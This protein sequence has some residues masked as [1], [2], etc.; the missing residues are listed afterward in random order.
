L[1][2]LALVVAL[3]LLACSR[4]QPPAPA[5]ETPAP[6]PR[7]A[8]PPRSGLWVLA[9][10]DERVLEHAEK[11]PR[12]VERAAA[13]G[14]TDLFVQVYRGGRSWFPSD[15]AD[16]AP[17]RRAEQAAGAAPL[18]A[19]T[20]QA[21]A[22]GLRVHAWFNALS[23]AGNRDAPLLRRLGRDAVLVDRRG[24]N[25]LDYPELE[26]PPPDRDWLRVET[27]ALWLDPAT[28]GVVEALEAV[29]DDLV[30]AAPDLDGLH[31]DFIRST[32]T[33][34]ML[35][36]S[37]FSPGLD[38]GY[39][40]PAKA[41]FAAASGQPFARGEA[42]DDWRRERISEVVRRLRARI[43]K[44]W[45]HSAAVLPWADR[46]YLTALQDWRR[47]LEEGSIDFAV[48]M[49]YMRDDR[50]LR[51][52][53]TSLTGGV[54]GDRV[55]IGLGAWL[56]ADAPERIEAQARIARAAGAPGIAF[57]SWD[58]LA[59]RPDA[60]AAIAGGAAPAPGQP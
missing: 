33:L 2:R 29:V 49:A 9:E 25:L 51:Y 21:H 14:V 57:F 11:I 52:V 22:R 8:A 4:E 31:L 12:L 58:S 32:Y 6:A 28:P 35:P 18:S 10:G 23:L 27:P 44:R 15:D 55:W 36:G 53:S 59:T 42:W 45:Q 19:L 34:P 50:L 7:A 3:L 43:P 16:D 30:R 39:G 56:L 17:Y 13:L 1:A 37:R 46:A 54:A 38:F 20:A 41:A 5:P 40:A 48:A 47:W 60:L 26:V 24:R